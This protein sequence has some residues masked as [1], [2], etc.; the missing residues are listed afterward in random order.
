MQAYKQSPDLRKPGQ[1]KW[2]SDD[3]VKFIRF[4]QWRIEQT[5]YGVLAF[6]TNHSYLGNPTF[7]DMRQSLL[8]SFDDIYVFDLHGN[9]KKMEKAP[10]GGKDENVFD[11]QQGVTIGLFVKRS[12][13]PNKAAQVHHAELYGLRAAKYKTLAESDCTSTAWKGFRPQAPFYLFV[14][15]DEMAR[16]EYEHGWK[17]PDIFSPN[18]DPAPGIVTT[19]DGFAISWSA[20]EAIDKVKKLLATQ[21]EAEARALFRL[22]SQDQWQYARAK[23]ELADG[24]WRKD[25]IPVLYRPFDS[26]WTVFNRN[27][28][29]HRRERV[30]RHMLTANNLGLISA[31]S[32]KSDIPDHFLC[33]RSITEAKTGESTTQ[34]ALF[35]LYLYPLEQDEVCGKAAA[36][37]TPGG[38][39]P[40]LAPEFIA[41]C[42]AR[43]KL[44]FVSDGRGDL[45]KTFG[46]E[47]VFHYAYAVFYSPTY[48][49]RYA[50]FLKID[51]SR[52]PLTGNT[53]LFGKLCALGEEL[54]GLHLMERLPEPQARYPVAEDSTVENVRYAEPAAGTPGRVWINGKQYF[55]NV[56]PEVWAYQ[57]GGYQVCQKWLKDRKGRQLSYDDLTH[58]RGIVAALSHTIELQAEIDKAIGGWPLR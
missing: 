30:M 38:R 13:T 15:Q 9:S 56:P 16:T 32:N 44:A 23:L 51:F 1:A 37:N 8:Q 6:V 40:N 10:D 21:D 4:A 27:V 57:I 55:G 53:A 39:R 20:D 58:Y 2:L 43:L 36:S 29:V 22:C 45:K 41:E 18:G 3:Y 33:S 28:A 14:P 17:V 35:P 12:Q 52:L 5:G 25:V 11:I 34:S 42:S 50:A 24:G 47:D 26:R 54:T 49:N 46:P 31:R 7:H 19:Q 48:R